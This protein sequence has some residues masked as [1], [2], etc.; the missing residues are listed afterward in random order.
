[1]ALTA[2]K[3]LLSDD[4]RFLSGGGEMGVLIATYPWKDTSLGAIESWPQGLR[5]ALSVM[6]NSR[7]PMFL[8]WGPELTSFYNDAFRPSLGNNGKHPSAL[9]QPGRVAW[10]D[11]WDEIKPLLDQVRDGGEAVWAEDTFV[12]FFR[13]GHLEETY[14]TF[15]YSSV[16]D[17]TGAVAGIFVTC[18]ETTKKVLN[19]RQMHTLRRIAN[20]IDADGSVDSVLSGSVEALASNNKDFPFA[21][22]YRLQ[23]N[24]IIATPL[25]FTGLTDSREELLQEIDLSRASDDAVDFRKAV[26][27]QKNILSDRFFV[28]TDMLRAGPN[29]RL[30]R[31]IYVP[32]THA[33]Y[34]YPPAV[35]V[36]ALNPYRKFD[37]MYHQ[38][39]KL[40]SDQI[41][42][43]FGRATAHEQERKRMQSLEAIVATCILR[44]PDNIVEMAN[45]PILAIMGKHADTV[46]FKPLMEGFPEIKDQGIEEIINGVRT[47]GKRFHANERLIFI[48]RNGKPEE[49][50]V[51]I[52]CEPL[53]EPDGSVSGVMVIANEVTDIVALRKSAQE[54]AHKF[55]AESQKRRL[56]LVKKNAELEQLAYVSS[57]DLQEPLRKIQT[58]ADLATQ[59]LANRKVAERYLDKIDSSAAR[60][61]GLIKSML[62][63][64]KTFEGES[65]F[66]HVNLNEILRSVIK[67]FEVMIAEK[68]ATI[69]HE[70]LPTL[71]ANTAQIH[72]LFSSLVSNAL[73]FSERPPEIIIRSEEVSEKEKSR[74]MISPGYAYV[75]ISF[76]DNGIGFDQ[77]Y[78]KKLFN[79]FQQLNSRDAY[80]GTGIGLSLCK[81]IAENH[82]GAIRGTSVEGEGSVFEVYLRSDLV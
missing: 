78:E 7:F 57:H 56:E 37:E 20:L 19:D 25:G 54:S 73:K 10:S 1:M 40:I 80:D 8:F 45:A 55:E 16:R 72:E 42:L 21:A 48:E 39:I 17:E 79:M 18:A 30:K 33:A 11:E 13:D 68:S 3:N 36:A 46:L 63:Y 67:D 31:F 58:F 38:F 66:E 26:L 61:S 27:S 9:G 34:E 4:C 12:P 74:Q 6:L 29:R 41:S 28:R 49:T 69:R 82:D 35:L 53:V 15:S 52:T 64:S 75:K 65:H 14:W 5:T 60:M 43:E 24:G 77:H 81:K 71:R 51:N 47:T 70:V 22:M 59:N 23:R 50:Y 76:R 44:G 2:G 62:L 32:I